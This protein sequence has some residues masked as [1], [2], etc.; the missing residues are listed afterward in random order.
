MRGGGLGNLKGGGGGGRLGLRLDLSLRWVEEMAAVKEALTLMGRR[1]HRCPQGHAR[2]TIAYVQGE[3]E[4]LAGAAEDD[5]STIRT[6]A[7]QRRND[8]LPYAIRSP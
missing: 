2:Y 4:Q 3:A 5:V 1:G 7:A 6:E 8:M